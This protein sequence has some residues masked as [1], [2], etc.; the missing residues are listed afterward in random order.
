MKRVRLFTTFALLFSLA[1]PL[2]AL[3]AEQSTAPEA[4]ARSDSP[5][6]MDPVIVTARG[7]AASQSETPGSVGVVTSEEISVDPK[8]SL[9]DSLTRLPGVTRT[10]DSPWGQDISIRGLTG[11]SIVILL[12]GKRINTATDMNA[13]LGFINPMD[14]ERI[15]VLKGPVSALYGSGSIGGVVNI[16]TRKADYTDKPEIHGRLAGSANSNPEGG[17]AYLNLRGSTENVW[18]LVSGALRDYDDT[19][20]GDREKVENSQFSDQQG[21]VAMGFKPWQNASITVEAMHLEGDDIGVPGGVSSMPLMAYVTYPRAGFTF[22]SIDGDVDVNGEYLKTLHADFYYTKNDRRVEVTN[23]PAPVLFIKPSADHETYGGKIQG[24]IEAGDHTIVAGLDFWTWKVTESTRTRQFPQG[25]LVD[26]PLPEPRQ[27]SLG[28]FAEDNWIL[29]ESF[30][31]NLGARLDG[32][33]TLNEDFY[34]VNPPYPGTS[35]KIYGADSDDDIGWH[36]HA[37]LTWDMDEAWSQSLLLASS[38]RAA[39]LMERFKYINLGGGRELYGNPNLDPEQSLYAEYGLHYA[40][41]PFSADLR[42]FVNFVT[43]YIAEKQ[44]S[45]TVIML[46]NVDDARIYGAELEARWQFAEHWGLYGNL[47]ALY[48]RDEEKNQ[49]LPGI[50]PLTGTIG[51]DY[52]HSSGLW[53]RVESVMTAPQ[54]EKPQGVDYSPGYMTMNVAA[55]YAFAIGPTKHE[56][57]IG[58]DNLFDAR[59]YNYLANMRGYDVWEP[60]LSFFANYSVDF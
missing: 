52:T 41:N 9:A 39:D 31:L 8:G 30:T 53:A 50:A 51:V 38:Y 46:E 43:N 2:C 58:V 60:G 5:L 18:G 4:A 24:T 55:G 34:K 13:R 49:P 21:R 48:G 28:I 1:L 14:I 42:L 17:S 22:A 36:L 40:K 7:Y 45:P 25:P 33:R 59:Y 20:G 11:P 37:G 12:N 54:H 19:Y 26:Q 23:T 16:I 6:L 56:I 3:A 27:T 29:N 47:S 32:V 10:G 15:E 57:S 44:Q 35:T